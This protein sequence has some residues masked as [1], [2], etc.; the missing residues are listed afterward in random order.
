MDVSLVISW[1]IIVAVIIAIVLLWREGLHSAEFSRVA[2][3]LMTSVGILGTFCG[4]FVALYPLDFAPGKMNDSIESLLNGMKTAFFTS[5][6]GISC[7]IV[8][9]AFIEPKAHQHKTAEEVA[10]REEQE[11]LKRLDAIRQAIAGDGDSSM[12]SQIRALRD[13]NR[14][15]FKKLDGLSEAIR[16]SLVE[17]LQSLMD[18]I[19]N[20]IGKQL[21]E[22]LEQLANEIREVMIERLGT[23]FAEL[24]DATVALN[25]WQQQHREQL[26]QLTAAFDLAANRIA[27]IAENCG[28]IPETMKQLREVVGVL[29]DDVNALNAQI[30]A[31]A[32]MRQQAE[33]FF[34]VIKQHLDAI[35]ENLSQSAKG[36]DGLEETIRSAFQN[37]E[38]E[39]RRI[40]E[41]YAANAEALVVNM[42]QAM[43]EA[44]QTFRDDIIKEINRMTQEWGGNLVS[45]AEECAKMM[46]AIKDE[47]K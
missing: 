17:N 2:P 37:S 21:K 16:E 15:G 30:Q 43:E 46:D 9:R 42:R 12:V 39:A 34:P 7:S 35:G 27:E 19:R 13:E 25:T 31:F 22:Q 10:S 38:Q 18:D 47:Q 1:M 6:L 20:I 28:K 45:I 32:G 33:E 4:I 8:Y 41:Q 5:L 11:V 26:E 29:Q 14:E 24:K 36:F 40:S 44:Q 3:S 23:T